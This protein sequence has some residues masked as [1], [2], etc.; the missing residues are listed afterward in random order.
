MAEEYLIVKRGL[1]YRPD[2]CGY[3]GIRDHAGRYS[4]AEAQESVKP[5]NGVSMVR[6]ADAPEFSAACFDDLARAHLASQRDAALKALKAAKGYMLNAKIDLETGTKKA[7]TLTTLEGGLRMVEAAIAET[8][9][10][11]SSG[12]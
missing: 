2:N 11:D 1:Y 9:G 7:T 3:T 4:L 8:A 12:V 6:A 5:G 10:A